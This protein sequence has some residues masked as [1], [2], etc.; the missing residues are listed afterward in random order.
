MPLC[1]SAITGK[2]GDDSRYSDRRRICPSRKTRPARRCRWPPN[3]QE[4]WKRS[5]AKD[6]FPENIELVTAARH[7]AVEQLLEND[8]NRFDVVLIDWPR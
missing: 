4:W 5:E 2:G 7:T 8:A 6:N 1:I 3:L